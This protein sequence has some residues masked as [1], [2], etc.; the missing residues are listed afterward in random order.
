MKSRR[1]E[2]LVVFGAMF[3]SRC[4][5]GSWAQTNEARVGEQRF[6]EYCAG[7]HG[8]DGRGGDKAPSLVAPSV[9]AKRSDSELLRVV[10]DGTKAGMPPFAQI[11][12]ANI[13]AVLQYVR[14]LSRNSTETG[15][16]A[17]A[18]VTG[19]IDAGRA[20][21]FGRAQCAHCHSMHGKGGFIANNLTNY[22]RTRTAEEVSQAIVN[23]DSPLLPSSQV[24]VATTKS[25]QKITGVLRNEDA[26]T[27]AL[28]TE[29]GRFHL[30]ARADVTDVQ[31]M[32]RSL[33][34]RDYG[35]RLTSKELND[36]VSFLIVESRSSRATDATTQ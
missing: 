28:Q 34:P 7:C 10:H 29:D 8:A 31:Y 25:G 18:A 5:S 11:G 36:I 16:L 15:T 24:A 2:L 35:T 30:L 33:M 17:E 13:S 9:T 27:L 21:Y 3:F 14:R 20:L 4:A 19:D 6:M 26:F 32:K 12:E 22:G 23:P 1:I